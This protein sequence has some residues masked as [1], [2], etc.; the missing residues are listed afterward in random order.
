MLTPKAKGPFSRAAA[1]LAACLV[2]QGAGCAPG[3][4]QAAVVQRP[5]AP[6]FDPHAAEQLEGPQRDRWQNPEVLVRKLGINPGAVVADIGSG[7]GYLLPHLS[8]AVGPTGRVHAEE[9]QESF[10]APLQRRSE[11]LKNV[12]VVHG[13]PEDPRLPPK[14]VDLFVMLTVYH[15]V[16]QPVV[17]LRRLKEAARPGARLAIIDFD[18]DRKGD[19]PPPPEHSVRELAV[20]R[21]VEQAGW[22][23]AER[24]EVAP[25][26]FFLVFRMGP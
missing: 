4:E 3:P 8:R 17:L 16:R 15:E 10:L 25:S 7:T 2:L 14:S 11:R 18:P 22:K 20:I 23:L 9:I 12:E 1:G 6:P 5:V 13:S 19:P 26:Q 24:H 21:E